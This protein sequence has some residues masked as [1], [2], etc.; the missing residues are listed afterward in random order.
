MNECSTCHQVI[1]WECSLCPACE[2]DERE[3]Q[4]AAGDAERVFKERAAR[5]ACVE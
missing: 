5:A 3:A 4:E 1:G 2:A